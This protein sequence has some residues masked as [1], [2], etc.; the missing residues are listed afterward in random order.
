LPWITASERYRCFDFDF[1]FT[2]PEAADC[3]LR[4]IAMLGCSSGRVKKVYDVS[5]FLDNHPGG[6][7]I[8][9]DKAGE[10]SHTHRV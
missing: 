5:K 8:V 4:T 1:D 6:P 7:E 2:K 10:D 9:L 3:G